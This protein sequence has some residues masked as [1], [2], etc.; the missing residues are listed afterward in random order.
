KPAVQR[1]TVL[2]GAPGR[3]RTCDTD[4]RRVVLYPLSYEGDVRNSSRCRARPAWGRRS[5]SGERRHDLLGAP[6]TDDQFIVIDIEVTTTVAT[7]CAA[8]QALELR[9]VVGVSMRGER[10]DR[11]RKVH[12]VKVKHGCPAGMERRGRLVRGRLRLA[13]GQVLGLRV[14]HDQWPFTSSAFG[15]QTPL[16][17]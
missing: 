13:G 15:E 10:L 17:Q 2:L 3:I 16:P 14:L 6:N 8:K 12:E 11:V 7:G 1:V 5:K 4:F 9:R